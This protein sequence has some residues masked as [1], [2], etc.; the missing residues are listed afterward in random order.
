[1]EN[2]IFRSG[3]F[4]TNSDTEDTAYEDENNCNVSSFTFKKIC[5]IDMSPEAEAKRREAYDN[6][7]KAVNER[8]KE[9]KRIQKE[10]IE[11]ERKMRLEKEEYKKLKN[12]E[13]VKAWNERKRREAERK[14]CR[15]NDMRQVTEKRVNEKPKEFKKAIRYEDWVAK[16]NEEYKALKAQQEVEKRKIKEF[17]KTRETVSDVV[18]KKWLKNSKNAP[19]PVPLNRGLESL[20]GSTTKLYVNPNPWKSLEQ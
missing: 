6:W 17:T 2:E 3:D 4:E 11:T 13:K 5:R 14:I 20:R 16:K 15:L 12:D 9:K 1:M 8:E 19:K 7:L 18:F 10:R